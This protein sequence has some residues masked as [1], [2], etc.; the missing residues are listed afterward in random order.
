MSFPHGAASRPSGRTRQSGPVLAIGQRAVVTCPRGVQKRV[1]LRSNDGTVAT[2][3][4]ATGVEVEILAWHPHGV[5]GTRYR[6]QSREG[7]EGW[8]AAA[9]LKARRA[10]S[11]T[12]PPSGDEAQAPGSNGSTAVPE[13][14]HAGGLRAAVPGT[15]KTARRGKR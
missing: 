2:A 3:T 1:T 13:R 9:S 14:L 12:L 6:I 15:T 5:N 4:V 10:S 8:L 7:V 11:T